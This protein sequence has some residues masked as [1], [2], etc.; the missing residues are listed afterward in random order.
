MPFLSRPA[1]TIVTTPNTRGY[2]ALAVGE[3][4]L[5]FREKE[6]APDGTCYKSGRGRSKQLDSSA[7]FFSVNP[8]SRHI[9]VLVPDQTVLEKKA[10]RAT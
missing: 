3:M 7:P 8:R 9:S 10:R 5:K 1:H 2:W 4:Y 6:A